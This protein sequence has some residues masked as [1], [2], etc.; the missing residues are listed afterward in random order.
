MSD[1]TKISLKVGNLEF[2]GE[3]K[4]QWLESQLD[5]LLKRISIQENSF[6][7]AQNGKILGNGGG[8]VDKIL[9]TTTL[10]S[11]LNE[12]NAKDNQNRKFLAT[13]V[14]LQSKGQNRLKTADITKAL[15]DSN[16]TRLGNASDTLKQNI[17]KGFCEKDGDN[18]FATSDGF[19]E[20]GLME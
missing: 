14:Y 6:Q 9:K 19:K 8:E 20:L 11:F 2:S 10:V 7:H 5:K 17:S 15:K 18:F 13:A 1:I 3:G 12:K 4:E 16:Q